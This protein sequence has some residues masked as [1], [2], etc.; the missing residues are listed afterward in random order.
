MSESDYKRP[1]V[2]LTHYS[3][4]QARTYHTGPGGLAEIWPLDL[5]AP[6]NGVC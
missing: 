3:A 6:V 1:F 4:D 2:N 5:V